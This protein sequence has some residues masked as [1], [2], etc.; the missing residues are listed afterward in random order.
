[1]TDLFEFA[2][3]NL[4]A[5]NIYQP[6]ADRM[7]PETLEDIFG[8]EHIL[9]ENKPLRLLIEAGLSG[10]VIFWGPPGCG[11]TTLA[12]V[13]ASKIDAD[14]IQLSAVTSGVKDLKAAFAEASSKRM[15]Y[16]KKTLLFIDEIH[17]FNKS[18]QDAL[19]PHVESGTVI[20]VG[21]TT[22]NPSFEVIS[23]L[24]SRCQ[25]MVLKPVNLEALEMILLRAISTDKQLCRKPITTVDDDAI[26]AIA[27]MAAGDARIALNTLE[28]CFEVARQTSPYK[29]I[30]TKKLVAET[31]QNKALRYDKGGEE[32]YNLISA[33]HKSMRGS[34]PD[35]SL[36]WLYRMIEGGEKCRFILRRMI[37]F[38][39]EDIGMADPFALT[40]AMSTAQAF[41]YVGPPEGHIHLAHLAVYLSTAP[42]S[43]A[44]YLAEK[45]VKKLIRSNEGE[46]GVPIHLRNAPTSLMKELSYGKEYKY[47]HDYKGGFVDENYF[48]ENV[49]SKCYYKPTNRGKEK[50]ITDLLHRLWPGRYETK[51]NE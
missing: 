3:G 11:K 13:L 43:N 5:S 40:L 32:H 35:A 33:L 47:P 41:E 42:K 2:D 19:L 15:H 20:F 29:P 24:L 26:S 9:G 21:A 16:Q 18:Q 51:G 49:H 1:M 22:E 25:V 12:R 14:F 23:A 48:P 31:F 45:A 39:S 10:S 27:S 7:R 4:S 34:D 50:N 8:Q 28:T 30:V 36:Y 38:A 17:R 46:P 6:L 44:L 37:R